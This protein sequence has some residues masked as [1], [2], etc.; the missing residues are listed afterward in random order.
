MKY[1]RLSPTTLYKAPDCYGRYDGH[2]L[3]CQLCPV[4]K[5]CALG[6]ELEDKEEGND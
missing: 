6:Q 2:I 5:A 3:R 1:A 4:A